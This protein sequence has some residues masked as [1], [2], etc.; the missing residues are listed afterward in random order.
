MPKLDNIPPCPQP[1]EV[2]SSGRVTKEYQ[3]SLVTP[4]FGGGAEAGTPDDTM[5]IRG[6]SIRGQLQFWWRA[7]RGAAFAGRQELFDRH[8]EIWGTTDRASPVDVVLRDVKAGL[9]RPCARYDAKSDGRLQLRWERQFGSN[10][11]L[12]Y[13]L[14]PFQGQLNRRRSTVERTPAQFIDSVSFTL[15]L[16]Y[17]KGLAED[18]E[19]AVRA[20]VNLGGLGARTRRGCGALLCRELA[21]RDL[22]DLS[23]WLKSCSFDGD[24]QDLAWPT[25]PN[26]LLVVEEGHRPAA[27]DSARPRH[28]AESRRAA[29]PSRSLAIPGTRDD[30][31]GG[32][33]APSP[34]RQA[35]SHPGRRLPA[36]RIRSPD[37]LPF[38]GSGRTT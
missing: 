1:P 11:E 29:R 30:P 7:T 21:P 20:W 31:P 37:R 23:R 28:W 13:A 16:R 26:S 4:L 36:R 27:D 6:T 35:G 24:G 15:E 19:M 17:P 3:I 25:M 18:V 33:Q 34:A 32:G 5:P 12:Q 8:A 10:R 38:P 22:A 9:L 2:R 14:F